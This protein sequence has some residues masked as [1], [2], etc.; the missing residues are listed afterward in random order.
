MFL[1][2]VRTVR[3][4]EHHLTPRTHSQVW[5][6]IENEGESREADGVM[7]IIAPN[8]N[9]FKPLQRLSRRRL[10]DN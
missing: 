7:I 1:M 10:Y 9:L 3:E 5:F 6:I 8:K 2:T 4:I